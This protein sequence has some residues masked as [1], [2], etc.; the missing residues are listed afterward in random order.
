MSNLDYRIVSKYKKLDYGMNV[1]MSITA[2][3]MSEQKDVGRGEGI[4][5]HFIIHYYLHLKGPSH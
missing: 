3:G 4:V 2:P 1:Q 5:Q